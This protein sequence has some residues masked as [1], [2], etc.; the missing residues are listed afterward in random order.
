MQINCEQRRAVEGMVP[1]VEC[2]FFVIL[3][4]LEGRETVYD[5][6]GISE[7][8][9]VLKDDELLQGGTYTASGYWY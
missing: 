9:S 4:L 7:I 1:T 2:R 8:G 5:I 6:P 3:V